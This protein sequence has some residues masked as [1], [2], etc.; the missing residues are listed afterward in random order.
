[1]LLD[2]IIPTYNRQFMLRRTLESLLLA[3]VPTGLTVRVTVVDN[4]SIDTTRETVAGYANTFK[5]ELSYVFEGRQGRSFAL[6]AGIASTSGDL[7][8]MIDDDEEVDRGWYSTIHSIFSERKVDFIGGPYVPR[9]GT[10]PPDWLPMNYL[11]A[12]GWI[13]GGDNVVPFGENYPGILMGGNAVLTRAVVNKV[14]LY[15]TKLGR[16]GT[17][18]L[19]GE[20]D[21]MY[22]RLL[23]AG[24]H[25]LYIPGLIIYHYIPPERLMKSYFRRWCFWRGVSAGLIDR[26]RQMPVVY[27]GGVPRYLYG[28]V[29]RGLTE[30]FSGVLSKKRRGSP[31]TF[32]SELGVWDSIGFFY[33]KHF[34]KPAE[35]PKSG[36][37]RERREPTKSTV[38]ESDVQKTCSR[39]VD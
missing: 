17:R 38:S 35:S 31:R 11:G 34:Y 16:N 37:P 19:A 2:V 4:N 30:V 5:E 10:K 33:G 28:N 18:L 29:A 15:N 27:F 23:A 7:I 20:D 36:S 21:D 14:G 22:E 6:N 1:M 24:A 32:S 26:E 9:W 39:L 13:D 25:G 12:I 8:G 3:E